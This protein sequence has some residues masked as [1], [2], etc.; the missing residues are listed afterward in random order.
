MAIALVDHGSAN[1]AGVTTNT[2]VLNMTG[3]TLLMASVNVFGYTPTGT[4]FSDSNNNVWQY[5]GEFAGNSHVFP[6]MFYA[7]NPTVSA[8]H[9]FTYTGGIGD[10]R[11][12]VVA[13]FSGVDPHAP[14]DFDLTTQGVNTA[15]PSV[16][17]MTPSKDNCLIVSN[18]A[19]SNIAL[20]GTGTPSG[21]TTADF[22]NTSIGQGSYFT[23]QVQTTAT[24]VNPTWGFTGSSDQWAQLNMVVMGTQT[25]GVLKAHDFVPSLNSNICVSSA[26]DTTQ[27]NFV[28]VIV[29]DVGAGTNTTTVSD[30]LGN[31][32]TALTTFVSGAN[33]VSTF[34]SAT[35][36]VSSTHTVTAI[37]TG[38]K[39]TMGVFAFNGISS[40]PFDQIIGAALNIPGTLTPGQANEILISG[41]SPSSNP[42]VAELAGFINVGSTTDLTNASGAGFAYKLAATP[43]PTSIQWSSNNPNRNSNIV[44][45]KISNLTTT[46]Q[47]I[48]GK[49]RIQKSATQTVT[50]KARIGLITLKT[51][52]G[53]ARIG[54]TTTKTITGLARILKSTTQTITGKARITVSVSKTLLGRARIK[55][56]ASQTIT[57]KAA[58]IATTSQT[59]TGKARLAGTTNRTI[60]GKAAITQLSVQTLL[61][62]ARLAVTTLQTI[63]GKARIFRQS[64]IN[65][66]RTFHVM[67]DGRHYK[68]LTEVR[69]FQALRDE[70]VWKV[71]E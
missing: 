10:F 65:E 14:I 12:V 3:A 18:L 41:V 11:G 57:G 47:T 70:R 53:Q 9:T 31:V 16:S 34:Y 46:N 17:T 20:N 1:N 4:N 5:F 54:S 23:Y 15:T 29:G 26:L 52:L 51:L 44:A 42:L 66:S 33:R 69:G 36:T 59:I 22:V 37:N 60:T 8:T 56:T 61:G 24:A 39:P 63:L 30:N 58:L 19:Y 40:T 49:A 68:P 62:Q 67:A 21:F 32:Y 38:A 64:A 25:S 6:A 55:A 7:V 28:A 71:L 27:A 13:G 35:P 48:T 2:I 45:F 43:V 50:G